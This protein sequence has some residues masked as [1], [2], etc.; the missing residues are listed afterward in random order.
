MN[1]ISY[2]SNNTFTLI[3]KH[4]Y[5]TSSYI[6]GFGE[7]SSFKMTFSQNEYRIKN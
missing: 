5:F 1:C 7:Y 3:Q 4:E 2:L 6:Y